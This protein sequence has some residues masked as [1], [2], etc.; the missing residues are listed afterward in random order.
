M[1]G[2]KDLRGTLKPKMSLSWQ[3]PDYIPD[4]NQDLETVFD[5]ILE[6]WWR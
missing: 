4:Q 1:F 5:N 2:P 6:V 3:D